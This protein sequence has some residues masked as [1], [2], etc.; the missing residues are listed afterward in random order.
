[1]NKNWLAILVCASALSACSSGVFSSETVAEVFTKYPGNHTIINNSA[2]AMSIPL[3]ANATVALVVNAGTFSVNGVSIAGGVAAFTTS[4]PANAVVLGSQL[5]FTLHLTPAAQ[6]A[7]TT[8]FNSACTSNGSGGCVGSATTTVEARTRAGSSVNVP[9]G[10]FALKAT[11]VNAAQG[12]ISAS[13]RSA[14]QV[15]FSTVIAVGSAPIADGDVVFLMD[16]NSAKILA[17][18]VALPVAP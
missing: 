5:G 13:F 14:N 17:N 9:A 7:L 1:M 12:S 4:T 11:R 2:V 15:N 6:T 10:Y 16:L 18:P 3:E 8:A